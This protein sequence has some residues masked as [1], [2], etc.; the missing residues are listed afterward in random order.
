V[1]D[2]LLRRLAQRLR[3]GLRP[4]DALLSVP[5]HRVA[6]SLALESDLRLAL[7]SGQL[8][9]VF[10]PI[11]D[12]ASGEVVGMEALARLHHPVRGE[13]S[14]VQFI[15]VAEEGGLISE[16]GEKMLRMAC[17]AFPA[18][19]ARGLA[20]SPRLSVNLSRAQLIGRGLPE[21]VAALL[22]LLRS[23]ADA[24]SACYNA[25]I[26]RRNVVRIAPEP[27]AQPAA[28]TVLRA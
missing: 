23:T 5:P 16:L 4:A 13:V 21:R 14:P 17:T 6:S 10:Q 2:E 15:A 12:I 26:A 27:D 18:W 28:S 22:A 24:D 8:W 9:A 1:G 25:K 7:K 19:L 3:H 20:L 11:V